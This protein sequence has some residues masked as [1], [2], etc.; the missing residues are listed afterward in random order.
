MEFFESTDIGPASSLEPAIEK[1]EKMYQEGLK[2]A[3]N[4]TGYEKAKR[5]SRCDGIAST[6]NELRKRL[7]KDDEPQ[8][9]SRRFKRA[10]KIE[11]S[12]DDDDEE[13]L[14]R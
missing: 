11:P 9:K 7:K 3:E 5:L 2:E 4:Y 13:G 12:F 8:K 1:L 6:I 14:E 10:S